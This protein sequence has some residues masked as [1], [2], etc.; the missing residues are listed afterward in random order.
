[1]LITKIE[2]Y[3]CL[4]YVDSVKYFTLTM[5]DNQTRYFMGR[6]SERELISHCKS[7]M[8]FIEPIF[9]IKQR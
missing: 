3:D 2:L 9:N 1:M 7:K 6:I 8:T 4:G 5:Y